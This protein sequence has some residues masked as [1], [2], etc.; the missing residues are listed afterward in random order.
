MEILLLTWKES[1][2]KLVRRVYGPAGPVLDLQS[3]FRGKCQRTMLAG[4]ARFHSIRKIPKIESDQ[5]SMVSWLLRLEQ[6]QDPR[7]VGCG[8]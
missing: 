4:G 8:K 2:G 7:F 6:L 3:N 5:T 1:Y